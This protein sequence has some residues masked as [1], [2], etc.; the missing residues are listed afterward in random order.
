MFNIAQAFAA[1]HPIWA[2]Y[3][4]ALIGLYCLLALERL[5]HGYIATAIAVIGVPVCAVI[6]AQLVYP[7]S[8]LLFLA[9]ENRW[10]TIGVTVFFTL[11]VTALSEIRSHRDILFV[12]KDL[13]PTLTKNSAYKKPKP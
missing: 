7:L 1:D 2:C 11:I 10:I 13:D 4:G 5:A 6:V 9:T 12:A 3:F 8:T